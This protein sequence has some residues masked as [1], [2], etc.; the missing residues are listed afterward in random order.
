[1]QVRFEYTIGGL[2]Y[3]DNTGIY[4]K[5]YYNKY[6]IPIIIELFTNGTVHIQKDQVNE[7]INMKNG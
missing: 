7:F 6:G 4:C 2:V 5:L 1:M 3:Q